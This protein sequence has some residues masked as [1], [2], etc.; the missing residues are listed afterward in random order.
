MVAAAGNHVGMS[1]R[2]YPCEVGVGRLEL[3]DDAAHSHRVPDKHGVREQ[4]QCAGLVHHL[5]V[6]AGPEESL[7]AEED[8]P[9][10]SMA[11]LASIQLDANA[12]SKF[13]VAHIAQQVGS[14]DD[15]PEHSEGLGDA[16]GPGVGYELL[17]HNMR[18]CSA[19]GEARCQTNQLPLL[20]QQFEI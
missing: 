10:K 6:V 16:I 8:P 7:V 4:C 9:S 15:G 19:V 18:G 5:R 3:R 12:L 14:L 1:E 17:N 11:L 2:R 13:F 20:V